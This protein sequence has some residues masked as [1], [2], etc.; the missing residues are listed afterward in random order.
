VVP[1]DSKWFTRLVVS[2]V[3][4]DTL[5]SLDLSY[6]KVDPAKRKELGTAK[7]VLLSKK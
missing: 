5:E 2:M 6:P 7:K 1:A 3:L 4:V